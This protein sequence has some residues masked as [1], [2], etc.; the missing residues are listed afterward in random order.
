MVIFSVILWEI[1]SADVKLFCRSTDTM[2]FKFQKPLQSPL[3]YRNTGSGPYTYIYVW[4]WLHYLSP[5]GI[6]SDRLLSSLLLLFISP[7]N[8][9]CS[10]NVFILIECYLWEIYF[11]WCLRHH[12]SIYARKERTLNLASFTAQGKFRL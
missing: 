8:S 6:N 11:T 1:S 7:V 2:L 10:G 9:C 12:V 3:Q 4:E 5:T